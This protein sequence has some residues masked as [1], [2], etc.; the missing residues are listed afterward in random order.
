MAWRA[1]K[2][3]RAP[4]GGWL[5]HWQGGGG[6]WRTK[7][8]GS[9]EAAC[10]LRGIGQARMCYKTHAGGRTGRAGKNGNVEMAGMQGSGA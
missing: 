8:K 5:C 7:R 6:R 9:A 1:V 3:G 10:W 2:A 4:L